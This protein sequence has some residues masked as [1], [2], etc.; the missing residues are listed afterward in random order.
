MSCKD[1]LISLETTI[2]VSKNNLETKNRNPGDGSVLGIGGTYAPPE[3][4]DPAMT[5]TRLT[6]I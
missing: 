4:S 5:R 3:L 6:D 1:P 2:R